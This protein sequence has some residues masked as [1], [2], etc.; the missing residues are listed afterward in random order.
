[1]HFASRGSTYFDVL[2]A[3]FCVVLVVSNIAATKGIEFGSWEFSIGSVQIS[4]VV[5]D[6]GAFLFP[7]AYILGDV[8]SEVYGFR[9]ARR[10]IFTGFAMALVAAGTFWVVEQAPAASF[11]ENQA[12]FESVV[13]PV[14]QIVLASVVGYVVGQFINSWVLVRMKRATAERGLFARLATSTGAGEL[15]DTFLFCAIAASAIG[16]TSMGVFWNYFVVGVIYKVGRRADRH[17]AD[18]GRHRLAEAARAHVLGR[19][20]FRPSSRRGTRSS[21]RRSRPPRWRRACRRRAARR[22]ARCGSWRA[23]RRGTRWP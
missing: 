12:A 3:A 16:I 2:L 14:A 15:A 6:G 9:A 21:S 18:D 22:T 8:I 20:A 1:M 23:S 5:T 4:P 19:T 17:A 7:L 11:Y 13:G 10:A